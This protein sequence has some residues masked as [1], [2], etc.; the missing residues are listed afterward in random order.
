MMG[1]M[2]K[3]E[4]VIIFTLRDIISPWNMPLCTRFMSRWYRKKGMQ[5]EGEPNFLA[6][7]IWFDGSDYSRIQLGDGCTIS[8]NV[9]VITHDW[10]PYTVGQGIGLEMERPIGVHRQ[11]RIGRYA[12]IGF[13]SM[14]LPGAEIGDGAIVGAGSVVR[15][16]VPPWTIVVGN[17]AT[18]AGDSREYLLRQLKRQGLTELFNKARCL[19]KEQGYEIPEDCR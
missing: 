1:L 3:I 12:F 7:T 15:G 2:S 4:K 18:P 11:I 8:S 9:N 14:L 5:I 10:S 17:P 13:N 19:L 16:M 6:A